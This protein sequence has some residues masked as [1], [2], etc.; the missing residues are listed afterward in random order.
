MLW[1]GRNEDYI[2]YSPF[3]S[4]PEVEDE[5]FKDLIGQMM[6]LNPAKRITATQ[7]LEHP[8]FEGI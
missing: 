1:E 2:G 3:S 5:R 6:S 7:A 8:W 4:W